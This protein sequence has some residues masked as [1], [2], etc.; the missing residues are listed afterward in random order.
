MGLVVAALLVLGQSLWKIAAGASAASGLAGRTW[1]TFTNPIFIAGGIVYVVATALYVDLLSKHDYFRVQA[2]VVP[3][4]LV[5]AI[6]V[7][8]IKFQEKIS[9]LNWVG[10][11]LLIV[12]VGM[13]LKR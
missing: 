10:V 13:I 4:A 12:A 8:A 3:A 1:Q 7:S 9:L 11:V 5:L 2:V 6:A